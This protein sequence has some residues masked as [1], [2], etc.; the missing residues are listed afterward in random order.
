MTPNGVHEVHLNLNV[1]GLPL[2]ATLEINERSNRLI[3]EGRRVCKLGLGQSPFPVPQPV[4]EE[5]RA[6]AHQKDYLPV[7]GLPAL[8]EAV[9]DYYERTQ[10]LTYRPEHILVGP[11]SKELMFILQLV[12]YGDL[13][14]PTPSWVSY[15]P[16]AHIVGRHVQWVPTWADN[17]WLLTP[18]ELDRLCRKDPSRPR[19]VILNYPN[20]PTGYS[21]TDEQLQQIAEIA[22]KYHVILLSDEIYGELQYDGGHCSIARYYPEGTII[23]SGLS[24][25]CGA[26]GWRLGTFVFPAELDWL[27]ESMASVASETFTATS[28]PIQY[29]AVRAFAGGM[30]IERYLWQSRRILQAL[31]QHIHQRLTGFGIELAQ[32]D[33]GFYLFPDFAPLKDRLQARDIYNSRDLCHRIL[34]DTGVAM[35]PGVAFGRPEEELTLRLAFVDFDGARALAAAEQIE[36]GK[37]LDEI[38]LRRN[39][40]KVLTAFDL[41]EEWISD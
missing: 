8:R 36:A 7:R 14:I 3:K 41:L 17:K 22:R 12:Y 40:P 24:K 30:R 11:G 5:L 29:A 25:W 26:G 18:D 23:S 4:V 13:V 19:I 32:P 27:A 31:G 6:N 16:Q 1:R 2:S 33:G 9:V 39:C 10:G 15:A 38:F 20:N 35:L 28:A 37:E 34:E 21:Y